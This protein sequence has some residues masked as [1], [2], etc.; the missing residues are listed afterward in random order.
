MGRRPKPK[1]L[2]PDKF[3]ALKSTASVLQSALKGLTK[4]WKKHD[5]V[6]LLIARGTEWRAV[7]YRGFLGAPPEWAGFGTS[8]HSASSRQWHVL[9][10]A[11]H[12]ALV[13]LQRVA[14]VAMEAARDLQSS[15]LRTAT[16]AWSPIPSDASV[17]W[18]IWIAELA[19]DRKLGRAGDADRRV[20]MLSPEH[21]R[22]FELGGDLSAWEATEKAPPSL[23]RRLAT[24]EQPKEGY[25]FTPIENAMALSC[26]LVEG[27]LFD[28][29]RRLA[30]NEEFYARAKRGIA[31]NRGIQRAIQVTQGDAPVV[32]LLSAGLS[33]RKIAEQTGVSNTTVWR[34]AKANR[35]AKAR[36]E[37]AVPPDGTDGAFEKYPE[38]AGNHGRPRA[39]HRTQQYSE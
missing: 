4:V 15:W 3:I 1:P 38:H 16:A 19:A 26:A 25:Y 12:E 39:R 33:Y 36:P 11:H 30:L 29:N 34:I 28:A 24:G 7:P 14:C 21:Q 31:S 22:A 35:L 8:F 20:W 10:R 9:V 32:T 5:E 23:V 37:G 18:M 27:L 13:A 6:T 2:S 17:G